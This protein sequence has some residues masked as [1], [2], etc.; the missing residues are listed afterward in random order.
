MRSALIIPTVFISG[1]IFAA[2]PQTGYTGYILS[3]VEAYVDGCVTERAVN[4]SLSLFFFPFFFHPFLDNCHGQVRIRLP[5][6]RETAQDGADTGGI[7]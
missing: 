3:L 1:A 6:F 2:V 7:M 4:I 5:R